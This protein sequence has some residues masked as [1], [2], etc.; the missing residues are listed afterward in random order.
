MLAK[1]GSFHDRQMREEPDILKR[2][3]NPAHG[4][5]RGAGIIQPFPL[6]EHGAR[7]GRQHPRYQVE[8]G[9]LAR[10]VRADQSVDMPPLYFHAQIVE[11]VKAAKAL[12]QP[13]DPETERSGGRVMHGRPSDGRGAI[14]ASNRVSEG[15]SAAR[16]W[17][18]SEGPRRRSVVWRFRN[19][20][21]RARSYRRHSSDRSRPIG[22]AK[23]PTTRAEP[24]APPERR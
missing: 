3:R 10:S 1:H 14:V 2:T 5:L 13:L 8:E 17:S 18:Q 12:G 9:R 22:P 4:P 11:R 7:I 21:T 19:P 23:A 20:G 6:E 24:S 16:S 15:R